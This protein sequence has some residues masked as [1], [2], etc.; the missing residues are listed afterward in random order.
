LKVLN[1]EITLR[2]PQNVIGSAITIV[3]MGSNETKVF[4]TDV[5][6]LDIALVAIEIFMGL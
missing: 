1:N 6:K 4:D 2:I 3:I 5:C